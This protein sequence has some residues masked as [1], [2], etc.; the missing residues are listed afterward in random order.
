MWDTV[1]D[2]HYVMNPEKG[3][4]RHTRGTA[5]DLRWLMKT[6]MSLKCHQSLTT[7]L[8]VRIVVT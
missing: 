1:R 6:E 4:G 8:I 7:L 2:E 3:K 5:V